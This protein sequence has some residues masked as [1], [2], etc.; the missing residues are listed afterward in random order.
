MFCISCGSKQQEGAAFCAGC[1]SQISGS[2]PPV[3]TSASPNVT[4]QQVS[5]TVMVRDFRCNGCGT[6]LKIPLK[7]SAPVKCP[8]CKTECIIERLV[9]NA[10]MAAKENIASGVPL[11]ATPAKLHKKLVSLIIQSPN[12]PM[13]IFEKAE[14]SHV[15][16]HCVP[17]FYFRCNG[18]ASYN[19]E[20][21]KMQT[22]QEQGYKKHILSGDTSHVIKTISEMDW[23][24]MNG[25]A[26][27]TGEMI[28]PGNKEFS[29]LIRDLYMFLDLSE[30]KDYCEL[31]YPSDV[32]THEFNFPQNA[33]FNEYVQPYIEHLLE[34]NATKAMEGRT[35]RNFSLAGSR[36]E[37]DEII[38]IFLG[39]YCIVLR[40]EG[41]EYG[42]W[43]TGD[44]EDIYN[45]EM[46][47]DARLREATDVKNMEQKI[48]KIP[49][50]DSNTL[51]AG[52][53]LGGIMA[54]LGFGI[55]YNGGG[56]VIGILT[57]LVGLV[58][59]AASL[60]LRNKIVKPYKERCN[61][62]RSKFNKNSHEMNSLWQTIVNRFLEQKKPLRG[63][64]ES[65]V[66]GDSEAF[67]VTAEL[68]HKKY[69]QTEIKQ[70]HKKKKAFKGAWD[71]LP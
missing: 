17:A 21:G 13:N 44:G 49:A 6:S 31:E 56:S 64:F 47:V 33:S 3:Q 24:Q 60:F 23:T 58:I 19:F 35:M 37:K 2:T 34:K 62:I 46:P 32:I 30:L 41:V 57:I 18:T 42:I 59:G 67:E 10:E 9:Q 68:A 45:T 63:V 54:A 14:I 26:H 52:A 66:D 48:A 16:H 20:A 43:M 38:R 71:W 15:Q 5:S 11:S 65:K 61:N 50:P 51:T 8:A 29:S 12:I 25:T 70:N 27:A 55:L 4:R 36:I 7:S 69:A 40:Y 39:F 1:G 28:A 22:R 53:I